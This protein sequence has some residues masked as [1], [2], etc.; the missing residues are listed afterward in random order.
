LKR[1]LASSCAGCLQAGHMQPASTLA[2]SAP[3]SPLRGGAGVAVAT[4]TGAVPATCSA[5]AAT[6][7]GDCV[8]LSG[9]GTT[10]T[11]RTA[12]DTPAYYYAYVYAVTS[13]AW[14]RQGCGVFANGISSAGRR[15]RGFSRLADE[16]LA[17]PS[18]AGV[19]TVPLPGRSD[20]RPGTSTARARLTSLV[21]RH[22]RRRRDPVHERP[23][24]DPIVVSTL[25]HSATFDCAAIV[26]P[27]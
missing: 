1:C 6:A 20:R 23:A 12:G 13:V 17:D 10:A 14:S 4:G 11:V 9:D 3:S 5:A 15:R 22:H 21:E 8:A 24:G 16:R 26:P 18:T 27:R 25:Q 7:L 19:A 2:A